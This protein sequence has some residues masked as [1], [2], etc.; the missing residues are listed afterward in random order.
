[1]K[2]VGRN[3]ATRLA[4]KAAE[5]SGLPGTKARPHQL[6]L[7][8]KLDPSENQYRIPLK[9]EAQSALSPE[10]GRGLLDRDSFIAIGYAMG[11]IPVPVIGGVPIFTAA[12]PVFWPDPNVFDTA[13]PDANSLSENQTMESIYWGDHSLKTNEGVRIDKNPN[14]IFRTVQE[15]QASGSTQNMMTGLHIQEIG[16]AVRFSGGDEN[17]II[18]NIKCPQKA[19][20]AGTAT[21]QNYLLFILEGSIIKGATNKAYLNR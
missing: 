5:K 16:A 9:A 19:L 15:T 11:I 4:R 2:I 17:E 7:L 18:V 3:V 6:H 8:A 1:M 10:I 20:I 21:R 12:A 13:A 14:M